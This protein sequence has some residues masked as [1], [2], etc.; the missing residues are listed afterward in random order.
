M[1]LS[2]FCVPSCEYQRALLRNYYLT[3]PY[4]LIRTPTPTLTQVDASDLSPGYY[5]LGFFNMDY[6]VHSPCQYELTLTMSGSPPN[7]FKP[8]M[9]I[10][11]GVCF[12]IVLC[13]VL[14]FFK[15]MV[16]RNMQNQLRS[17]GEL[18]RGLVVF[19]VR[20]PSL[21]YHAQLKSSTRRQLPVE[22]ESALAFSAQLSPSVSTRVASS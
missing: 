20:N 17:T 22:L 11:M 14:S 15:R 10:W 12:S 19:C 1:G 16:F 18:V 13:V 4:P 5:Y 8:M 21:S 9:S 3:Q 6:Y 7:M 2:A